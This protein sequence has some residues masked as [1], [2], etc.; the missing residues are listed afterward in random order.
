MQVENQI[1]YIYREA[2]NNI[3]RHA[4][5]SKV[6]VTLMW[7]ERDLTI[8]IQDDGKGFDPQKVDSSSHF[9]LM[10]MKERTEVLKGKFELDASPGLGTRIKIW[11]P[12]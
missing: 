11:L 10:I 1:L 9:G 5:A 8:N 6:E 2:L 3:E 7:R 4:E 12:V